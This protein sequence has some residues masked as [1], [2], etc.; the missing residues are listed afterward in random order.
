M[1]IQEGT[2]WLSMP[3][4]RFNGIAVLLHSLR[5]M[6]RLQKFVDATYLRH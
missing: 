6:L 5:P 1:T 2:S 3:F 4:L